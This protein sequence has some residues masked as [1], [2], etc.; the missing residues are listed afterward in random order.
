MANRKA[1]RKAQKAA[2]KLAGGKVGSEKKLTKAGR[3]QE[4]QTEP[5]GK[6]ANG[7]SANGKSANGRQL[8]GKHRPVG[9]NH[10]KSNSLGLGSTAAKAAL[11]I[12]DTQGAGSI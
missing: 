8:D 6:S 9:S 11:I 4:A 2:E 3:L 12:P 7:K 10:A 1:E 5:N